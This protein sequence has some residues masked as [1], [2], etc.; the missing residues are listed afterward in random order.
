VPITSASRD[1][2]MEEMLNGDEGDE[3]G[4]DIDENEEGV[5][6]PSG[7]IS[8]VADDDI[9]E[10]LA[11]VESDL[12]I[13]DLRKLPGAD[14]HTDE[15]LEQMWREALNPPKQR[16]YKFFKD[17]TEVSDFSGLSAAEL[18]EL[19]IAYP[20]M[21][22][23]QR[24][25]FD[26]LVRNAQLGHFNESRMAQIQQQRDEAAR[27]L[28]EIQPKYEQHSRERQLLEYALGQHLQGNS[29]PLEAFINAY[30]NEAGKLPEFLSGQVE[31]PNDA[32]AEAAGQRVYYETVVPAAS[33]LAQSYGADSKE[34]ERAIMQ[35]VEQ[36]P[37]QFM[38]GQRLQEIISV[39]LPMLLEKNG[40]TAQPQVQ[41]EDEVAQLR[42]ELAELKASQKNSAVNK[43]K[44]RKVPSAGGGVTPSV[45]DT[46]P[47][48]KNRN[49]MKDFLRS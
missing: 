44:N 8:T 24:R 28:A 5:E 40:Y 46:L 36:E 4:I 13:D 6:A 48:I 21:G 42:R 12:T 14:K 26:E 33:N 18:L 1:T 20:A 29:Q 30:R 11:A 47:N 3:V 43:A 35:L 10:Q 25:N 15:E 37:D 49:D 23:E 7:D 38:T 32:A 9:I 34:I 2:M 39:D 17:N 16:G 45:G 22:K 31:Q 41:K 19:Q 27:Q